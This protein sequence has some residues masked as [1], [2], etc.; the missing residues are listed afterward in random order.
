MTSRSFYQD[1]NSTGIKNDAIRENSISVRYCSPEKRGTFWSLGP[2]YRTPKHGFLPNNPKF[3]FSLG[4]RKGFI[5]II[6]ERAKRFPSCVDHYTKLPWIGKLTKTSKS[7]KISSI[8]EDA[9]KKQSIPPPN[10]YDNN[11]LPNKIKFTRFSKSI[12]L[13]F[14]IDYEFLSK[15]IPSPN[16]YSI[17]VILI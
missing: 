10:K 13:P 2:E 7:K 8:V 15:T 9:I 14:L 5:E 16:Q 6:S 11:K 17:K 4:N 3:K 12:R 1:K